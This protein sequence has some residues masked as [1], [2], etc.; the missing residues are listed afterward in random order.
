[1]NKSINSTAFLLSPRYIR[2]KCMQNKH[3]ARYFSD[4]YHRNRLSNTQHHNRITNSQISKQLLGEDDVRKP[5]AG[6]PGINLD[7]KAYIE[8]SNSSKDILSMIEQN[9][10][11]IEHA[12][13]FG[14]A[15]KKCDN[16]RGWQSVH[17]I[18]KLLLSS[19][20]QPQR[21]QFNV[22]FNSMAHSDS[23]ELTIKYFDVM[24]NEYS[25]QPDVV[26]FSSI[27]KSFRFQ[28]KSKLAEKFWRMMHDKY[29]LQPDEW[30]YTEMIS[31]YAKCHEI[32]KGTKLFNEYLDKVA[33]QVLKHEKPV[34][35]AY[36]N[37]F[38]RMG[39]IDGMMHANK[40]ILDAGFP[41]DVVTITDVMRG[42]L[43]AR[44]EDG[45][46]DVLQEWLSFDYPPAL[47]M[48]HLKCVAL[49]HKI[50]KSNA[51]FEDKYAMYVELKDTIYKELKHYGFPMDAL[52]AK[53]ELDGAIFLYRFHD[54]E[55][56]ID[57]FLSM[58]QKG[59]IEY[60]VYD[61]YSKSY[62]IDFH[63]FHPWQVQ[64]IVR[65]LI[66]FELEKLLKILIDD[67][68][69]IVV[70]VGKHTEGRN[71]QKGKLKEFLKTELQSWD[72]PIRCHE[73]KIRGRVHIHKSDLLP[74]LQENNY[75]KKL[76][77][78]QSKHWYRPE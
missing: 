40:L 10:N 57:V 53:T 11:I 54:P 65:Y 29:H 73:N 16:L 27:I 43:A 62:I 3:W 8:T 19:T 17:Q 60:K 67:K 70:G 30:L 41:S 69:L 64:F 56:I 25:I 18:M 21:I 24:V 15:M 14:K 78:A 31:V 49:T 48:M 32:E 33:R 39:N 7:I 68:L 47:P 26:C 20:L 76:L 66:G 36:L 1:M 50:Q 77:T 42:Y 37:M 9:V 58:V 74:Y 75:A 4:F 35:G 22:F 63:V 6:P 44:D 2:N 72:P 55:H 71:N 5:I 34:Y 59:V 51:S 61:T 46:L 38:S 45:C 28:G 52:I 12:S 23:P 13:I